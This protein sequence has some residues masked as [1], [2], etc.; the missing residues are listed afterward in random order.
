MRCNI[1]FQ[2]NCYKKKVAEAISD[3]NDLQFQGISK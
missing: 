1:H 2:L 3:L